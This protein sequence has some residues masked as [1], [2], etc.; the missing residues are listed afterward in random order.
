MSVET[1]VWDPFL[2]ER[3]AKVAEICGQGQKMGMGERAALLIIDVTT[4]FCGE[5]SEP[6]LESIATW[7]NS[8]GE[9]AW[10]GIAA[11]EPVLSAARQRDVPVI[12]S[13]S[14]R[15]PATAVHAG[16]W[17]SKNG[18]KLEDGDESRSHGFE[19][20]EPLRPRENEIVIQKSKPS[21]FFGTLLASYLVN[22]GVDTLICCG[23]TTSGC[24]RAT[25]VDAF[26]YNY[27]VSVIEEGCFD[28]TQASHAVGLFDM[29]QKY[30]DVITAREAIRHIEQAPVVRSL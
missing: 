23:T 30:A 20:V 3:D 17:A 14:A 5:R 13:A 22:L 28:R 8:C 27:R 4:A 2:T 10:T 7:R 1:R 21:A 16:R 24:V 19:I 18:R 12:Y 9:D 6:I 25:V 15:L 11:I 29:D 26:S